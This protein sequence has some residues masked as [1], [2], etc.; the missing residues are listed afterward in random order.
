METYID[1]VVNMVKKET[2]L[3]SEQIVRYYAL[4]VLV[5]GEDVTLSDVHDGWSMAM[6]YKESNPPYCYGHDHKSIIPFDELSK[7]TQDRDVI[8]VETLREIAREINF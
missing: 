2:G 8:Y 1:K 7:E 6:N 5:K 4:L 3:K